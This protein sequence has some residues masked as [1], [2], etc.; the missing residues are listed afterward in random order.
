MSLIQGIGSLIEDEFELLLAD[1]DWLIDELSHKWI[2]WK[3]STVRVFENRISG[4]EWVAGEQFV[5][6]IQAFAERF[7]AEFDSDLF[8]IHMPGTPYERSF[9]SNVRKMI[10]ILNEEAEEIEAFEAYEEERMES[11]RR[12]G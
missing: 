10:G 6:D 4:E 5:I 3:S 2:K 12:D 7:R 11:F 8:Y 1:F 9:R